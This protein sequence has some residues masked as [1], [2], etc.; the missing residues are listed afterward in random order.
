MSSFSYSF[1][2]PI[3]SILKIVSKTEYIWNVSVD[4]V[5]FKV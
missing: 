1:F 5:V 3:V 2:L 4:N